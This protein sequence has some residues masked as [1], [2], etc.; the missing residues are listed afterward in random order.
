MHQ[1][2]NHHRNGQEVQRHKIAIYHWRLKEKKD[3]NSD[4]LEMVWM[5]ESIMLHNT[6]QFL[7]LNLVK[8][9]I[10]YRITLSFRMLVMSF[11]TYIYTMNCQQNK[12]KNYTK[13]GITKLEYYCQAANKF[14]CPHCSITFELYPIF[15]F[16]QLPFLS[17]NVQV[18]SLPRHSFSISALTFYC[19]TFSFPFCL[20][21]L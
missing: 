13:A 19:G 4:T 9:Y 1:F 14:Y 5:L 20:L 7:Y 8:T 3:P 21:A 2:L 10:I 17:V 18:A 15:W 16:K 12:N 6:S 11:V